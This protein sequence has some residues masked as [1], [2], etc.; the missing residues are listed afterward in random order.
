MK[1]KANDT[2][3]EFYKPYP[4]KELNK[5]YKNVI[6]AIFEADIVMKLVC[7]KHIK[8]ERSCL[9]CPL[10]SYNRECIFAGL[11]H[12]TTLIPKIDKEI[13]KREEAWA[14]L[15]GLTGDE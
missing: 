11:K 5:E 4:E 1:K 7:M 13:E 9:D 3:I 12:L 8:A 14:E 6:D 2:G 10:F 15:H